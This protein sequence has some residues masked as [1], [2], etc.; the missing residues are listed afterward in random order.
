VT[1]NSKVKPPL[2]AAAIDPG[3]IDSMPCV[4]KNDRGAGDRHPGEGVAPFDI[5]VQDRGV[6]GGE[7]RNIVGDQGG[8]GEVWLHPGIV[9]R[10][11]DTG[12]WEKKPAGRG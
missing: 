2:A 7:G 6:E 3:T 12:P 5:C 1:W 10:G 9:G 11:S 8:A 4:E